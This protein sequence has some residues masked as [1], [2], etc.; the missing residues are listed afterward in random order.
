MLCSL[1]PTEVSVNT[2]RPVEIELHGID[3]IPI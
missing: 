2:P 1:K 3:T